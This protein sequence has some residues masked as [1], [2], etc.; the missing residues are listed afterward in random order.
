MQ[1]RWASAAVLQACEG[2]AQMKQ[3]DGK[4]VQGGGLGNKCGV[5]SEQKVVE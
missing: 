5:G 1:N 2:A 4:A 3:A